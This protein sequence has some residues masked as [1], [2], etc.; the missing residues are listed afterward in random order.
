MTTPSERA[1]QIVEGA[2]RYWA[3]F[4]D[5]MSTSV[6]GQSVGDLLL[7]LAA[8]IVGFVLRGLLTKWGVGTLRA[9]AGS[10]KFSFDDAFIDAV[11][12]P[13]KLGPVL[14]GFFV[15]VELLGID[16]ETV[17]PVIDHL[18]TA[19]VIYMVFWSLYRLVEPLFR[20]LKPLRKL[21]NSAV[22]DWARS[23]TKGI[24]AFVGGA[25]VLQEFGIPVAPL[26]GGL[27]IFGVAVA[28]GAQDL[29]KNLIAGVNILIER[30]FQ[31][32]EWIL[33]DG[34][35]EGT[36]E[37]I[38]FRSTKVRRFDKGPVYVPNTILSDNPV[39]N[40]SRMTHRRINWV[41]GVEYRTTKEQLR[42]I[43]DEIESYVSGSDDFALPPDVPMFVRIDK[44][45]NS[46]IDIML[47]CFTKT[48]VWGEWLEIKERLALAIK[49][50]VESAGSGFA[51]PSQ[52]I[53][54]GGH[55][56]D[57]PEVFQ[58]PATSASN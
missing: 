48:I 44:F 51:F 9:L 20:T 40:F 5:V 50:I 35:V 8:V 15:A 34:V 30:R 33:V 7:A 25:A 4:V 21:M 11:S 18:L 52:T 24:V 17:R 43:R 29:F 47:Y 1:D 46:S 6:F 16:D 45:S 58:P 54:F 14:L 10:T 31:P 42:R 19:A 3:D 39:T 32:G 56:G 28:L 22:I 26:L 37:K 27:G 12:P 23:V 57:A 2:R 49:D 41:I 13:L 55:D 36:V 38:G 53:Y